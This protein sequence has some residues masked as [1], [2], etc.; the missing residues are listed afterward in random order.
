VWTTHG[1]KKIMSELTWEKSKQDIL[2][3]KK[4]VYNTERL[5]F[6]IGGVLFLAAVVYLIILATANGARYFITLNDL[7]SNPEYVGQTVRITGAVVGETIKYDG[8][9]LIMDFSIAHVPTETQDLA[10]ALYI[11]ANDPNVQRVHVHMEGEV[12]PDLLQHE[13]Q[14]ILTGKLGTDGIFYASELLLKCPSRY[15]EAVPHQV[16]TEA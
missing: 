10:Y 15:E 13:A 11:A 6:L 8:K 2:S 12:K 9:N 16:N 5:K 3:S 1:E 4:L 14:A 7:M